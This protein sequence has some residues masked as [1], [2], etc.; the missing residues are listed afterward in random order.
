V[1]HGLTIPEWALLNEFHDSTPAEARRSRRYVVTVAGLALKSAA[2]KVFADMQT[3]MLSPSQVRGLARSAR[4][5][6]R[7]A[8]MKHQPAS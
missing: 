7:L 8:K 5:V 3:T 6:R 2:D 1:K 4:I